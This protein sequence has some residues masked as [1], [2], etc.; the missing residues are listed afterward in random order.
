MDKLRFYLA[1]LP[2]QSGGYALH[3]TPPGVNLPWQR[4]NQFQGKISS[5]GAADIGHGLNYKQL[6][7]EQEGIHFDLQGEDRS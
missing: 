5:R 1:S 4:R 7:L 3:L 6:L 2:R